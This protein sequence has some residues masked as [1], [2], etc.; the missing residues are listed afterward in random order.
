VLTGIGLRTGGREEFYVHRWNY[1]SSFDSSDITSGYLRPIDGRLGFKFRSEL[2][3]TKGW[4]F[5]TSIGFNVDIGYISES[6]KLNPEDLT[7]AIGINRDYA[8]KLFSKREKGN[9]K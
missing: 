9:T 7:F 8:T 6:T 2:P 1:L 5:T 4:R 3:L